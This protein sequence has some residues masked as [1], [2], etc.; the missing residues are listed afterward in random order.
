MPAPQ[1]L[2]VLIAF[3][4]LTGLAALDRIPDEWGVYLDSGAFTNHRLGRDVVTVDVYADFV[5]QHR[6][7][8]VRVFTL[9]KIGDPVTS[10]ANLAALEA[11]GLDVVPVF[12]RGADAVQLEAMVERYPLVGLGGVAGSVTQRATQEYIDGI[13]RRVPRSRVHLLGAGRRLVMRHAPAS[14][15][16]GTWA[17]VGRFGHFGLWHA[18]RV[19]RFSRLGIHR[20]RSVFAAPD[21]GQRTRVLAAYGARWADLRSARDWSYGGVRLLSARGWIRFARWCRARGT[22]FAMSINPNSIDVLREAWAVERGS[23]GWA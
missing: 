15:D 10:A 16:S 8:F 3:P 2:S 7:R 21:L 18:G 23:W 20:D 1:R 22:D 11:R 6:E 17:G 14:A 9:D 4:H 19:H 12:Q 13:M 5:E